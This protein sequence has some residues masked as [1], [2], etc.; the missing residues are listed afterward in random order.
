MIDFVNH[1]LKS[2]QNGHIL[3][4]RGIPDVTGYLR[5]CNLSVPSHLDAAARRSFIKQVFIAPSWPEIMLRMPNANRPLKKRLPPM[6]LWSRPTNITAT[7]PKSLLFHQRKT[8]FTITAFL[9]SPSSFIANMNQ[10]VY[11]DAFRLIFEH[12]RDDAVIV[13]PDRNKAI[14]FG[15]F[16]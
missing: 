10:I 13:S 7:S 4:D 1:R 2:Q 14:H 12:T 11:N 5:L 15:Q 8:Q 3:S 9:K 16:L 6:P